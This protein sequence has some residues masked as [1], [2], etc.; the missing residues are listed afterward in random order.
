V[1]TAAALLTPC[2]KAPFA[3]ERRLAFSAAVCRARLAA[4]DDPS[5]SEV[6]DLLLKRVND[7]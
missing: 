5:A 2:D 1:G 6:L 4:G 3:A 7:E